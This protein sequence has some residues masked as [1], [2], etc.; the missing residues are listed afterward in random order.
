MM[1]ISI[2]AFPADINMRAR[3]KISQIDVKQCLALAL[4]PQ[5]GDDQG[6]GLNRDGRGWLDEGDFRPR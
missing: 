5:R 6:Q 3:A 4:R 2:L 1:N